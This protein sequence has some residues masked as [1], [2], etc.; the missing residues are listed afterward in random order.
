M[1]TWWG[2]RPYEQNIAEHR[3]WC[4]HLGGNITY[5]ST[6]NHSQSHWLCDTNNLSNELYSGGVGKT[7]VTRTTGANFSCPLIGII[8]FNVSRW[9]RWVTNSWGTVSLIS[10]SGNL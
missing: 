9:Q 8:P 7:W 2:L 5:V 6:H 3:H 4:A 1:A 10:R